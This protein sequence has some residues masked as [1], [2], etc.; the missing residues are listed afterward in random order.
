MGTQKSIVRILCSD[1]GK[2]IVGTL[3]TYIEVETGLVVAMDETRDLNSREPFP[4]NTSPCN[5]VTVTTK[6]SMRRII[7]RQPF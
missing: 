3:S 2:T 7:V 5:I 1:L 6:P 4:T